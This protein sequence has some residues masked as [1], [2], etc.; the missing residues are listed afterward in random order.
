MPQSSCAAGTGG[1]EAPAGVLEGTGKAEVSTRAASMGRIE[2]KKVRPL[3][4]SGDKR[5]SG[6]LSDV[7]TFKEAGVDLSWSNFRYLMGG[8]NMPD[9][10]VAFWKDTATKMVKTPTWKDFMDKY[11][12]RDALVVDGF[13]KYAD[14]KIIIIDKV[15]A[16]LGLKR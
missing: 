4:V 13:D 6:V 16:G 7:P 2:S 8:P 10:A 15:A 14:E 9:Y 3:A 12:W 1:A 5:L 11:R